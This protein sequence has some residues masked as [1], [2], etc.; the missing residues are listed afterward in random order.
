M[1]FVVEVARFVPV[2]G[3][4]LHV[5]PLLSGLDEFARLALVRLPSYAL[6]KD[7]EALAALKLMAHGAGGRLLREG[8]S[9]SAILDEIAPTARR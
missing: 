9:P 1:A 7:P 6:A 8:R 3:A 5:S 2:T 4:R